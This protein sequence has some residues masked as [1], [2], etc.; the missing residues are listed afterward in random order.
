MQF[1]PH[2]WCAY[3]LHGSSV[4]MRASFHLHVVHDERLIVRSLLLPRSV[5][6][7]VSLRR[8]PLLF[9]T[10]PVL[11]PANHLQCGQRQGKHLLRLR[12][13]RSIALL[14]IYHPPTAE[15]REDPTDQRSW[16]KWR[17]FSAWKQR[18]SVSSAAED[19]LDEQKNFASVSEDLK[20]NTSDFPVVMQRQVRVIQ[21][22]PRTAAVP[23]RQ[24]SDTTIDVSVAKQRREDTTVTA[25]R[26]HDEVQ[27]NPDGQEATSSI[28]Q[29]REQEAECLRQWKSERL[30]VHRARGPRGDSQRSQR[31]NEDQ[32][33]PEGEPIRILRIW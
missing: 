22:A 23:L 10:L 7:R 6:L 2:N 11:C 5:F 29:D 24:Y 26:L 15:D 16:T 19:S 12:L 31:R 9:H 25:R 33:L 27:R 3:S 18:C 17:I 30:G 8:L 1:A 4:C 13:M 32:L 21:K 28:A 20:Q 14:T